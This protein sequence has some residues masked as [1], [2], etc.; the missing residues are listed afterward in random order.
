MSKKFYFLAGLPRSG[1]TVLASILNQH[2]DIYVTPTSPMLD[3][4]IEN[5]N[6]WHNC[7]SVKANPYPDQLTNVTRAMINS[8]WEHRSE[9]II[10]DKNRGWMKNMPASTILFD[11]EVK[12]IAT[13]RDL[14]SIMA[15]WLTL[16]RRNSKSHIH[17]EVISKG[18]APTDENLM[19]E[20]W[21]NMVQDCMEGL[22]QLKKDASNRLLLVDYD[23]LIK[24][25]SL[26]I[27]RL[28]EFLGL[29]YFELDLNNIKSD[30]VNNDI[31]AWGLK[32]MHEVRPQLT[33]S[34][35]KAIDILGE[36]LFKRFLEL[37]TNYS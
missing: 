37:E 2:P 11:R 23:K 33:R 1:S 28:Y 24:D 15:S 21:F 6:A 31:D 18:F 8:M 32:G 12:I 36:S 5:Q 34:A 4:L 10:I 7:P 16:L 30:D 20:M 17:A 35:L 26:L 22:V 25:P 27:N 29:D 9:S 19:A 14:P 13:V 3:L